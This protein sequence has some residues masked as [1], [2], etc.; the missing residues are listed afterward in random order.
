MSPQLLVAAE[1][2]GGEVA[3]G[4]L[5]QG[6]DRQPGR[7]QP[8]SIY[9]FWTTFRSHG[10]GK[11]IF[12]R[13]SFLPF[14]KS[15]F[16]GGSHVGQVLQSPLM[17][18]TSSW[19][20]DGE[21]DCKASCA[22]VSTSVPDLLTTDRNSQQN[23]DTVSPVNLMLL[24]QHYRGPLLLSYLTLTPEQAEMAL[25]AHFSLVTVY[26]KQQT[27]ILTQCFFHFLVL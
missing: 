9:N 16:S 18:V 4:H 19:G 26:V 15:F 27:V 24:S 1:G 12:Q 6:A 22:A 17:R 25:S 5:E 20:G 14:T 23:P 13:C 21:C 11:Q 3:S 7:A 10:K 8:F 2:S